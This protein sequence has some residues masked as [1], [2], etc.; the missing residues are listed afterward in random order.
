[1]SRYFRYHYNIHKTLALVLLQSC[2]TSHFPCYPVTLEES[3]DCSR[4]SVSSLF[5]K[6]DRTLR[7][8]PTTD[9]DYD[10]ISNRRVAPTHQQPNIHENSTLRQV[11]WKR[12]KHTDFLWIYIEQ[13]VTDFSSILCISCANEKASMYILLRIILL[14]IMIIISIV[15]NIMYIHNPL[16]Y[17]EAS[18]GKKE[19]IAQ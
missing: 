10:M 2:Y 17:M 16:W 7:K 11:L 14:I 12:S 3:E 5:V 18:K 4:T 1:M 15:Y 13:K 8:C 6:D 19:G 9:D